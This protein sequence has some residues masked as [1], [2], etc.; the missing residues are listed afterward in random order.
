M[1]QKK[2]L[3]KHSAYATIN[4]TMN[5]AQRL[6]FLD[7]YTMIYGGVHQKQRDRKGV[8]KDNI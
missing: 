1:A 5:K 7:K 6:T 2:E 3:A 8:Q 4:E